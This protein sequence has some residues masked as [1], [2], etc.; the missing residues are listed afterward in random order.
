MP[1]GLQNL[2]FFC[3]SQEDA[4][5]R[6]PVR[7]PGVFFYVHL[8]FPHPL[9]P[10]RRATSCDARRLLSLKL[11]MGYRTR[12]STPRHL[13]ETHERDFLNGQKEKLTSSAD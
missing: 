9:L 11:S 12:P 8:R 1:P 2:V 7:S 6:A 13:R 5:A 3:R 4:A 10:R